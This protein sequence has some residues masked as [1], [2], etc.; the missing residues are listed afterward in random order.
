MALKFTIESPPIKGSMSERCFGMSHLIVLFC[1]CACVYV[2]NQVMCLHF[3]ACELTL[4]RPLWQ[5]F[6]SMEN[7]LSLDPTSV[8]VLLPLHRALTELFFIAEA[9]AIV[10]DTV[11]I[12]VRATSTVVKVLQLKLGVWCCRCLFNNVGR[13]CCA[14]N[15]TDCRLYTQWTQHSWLCER[16]LLCCIFVRIISFKWLQSVKAI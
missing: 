5:L 13:F 8:T 6:I 3:R 10:S 11:C 14:Y 9:H 16:H 15:I 2:S 4:L 1:L 7:S 12:H